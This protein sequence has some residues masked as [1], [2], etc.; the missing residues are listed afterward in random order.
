VCFCRQARGGR[1]KYK[2]KEKG[3]E[4]KQQNIMTVIFTTLIKQI[5]QKTKTM[6]LMIFY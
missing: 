3:I 4:I 1:Y 6:L 2:N 5:P